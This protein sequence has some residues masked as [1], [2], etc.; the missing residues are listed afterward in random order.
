M[1]DE[2]GPLTVS[3]WRLQECIRIVGYDLAREFAASKIDLHRLERLA[4]SGCT[5]EQLKEWLL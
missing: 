5:P 3:E 1:T 4:Q 2:K